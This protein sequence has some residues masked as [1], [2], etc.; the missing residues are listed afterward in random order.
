MK[1]HAQSPK[2]AQLRRDLPDK[3]VYATKR[4]RKSLSANSPDNSL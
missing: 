3:I 2:K 4:L 1:S